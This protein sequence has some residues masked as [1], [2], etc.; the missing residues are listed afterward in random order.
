MVSATTSKSGRRM[1][2]AS[3]C[4]MGSLC[5]SAVTFQQKNASLA[6]TRADIPNC[7]P[8]FHRHSPPLDQVVGRPDVEVPGGGDDGLVAGGPRPRHLRHRA[9]QQARQSFGLSRQRLHALRAPIQAES[10]PIWFPGCAGE[11]TDAQR[12]ELDSCCY[13]VRRVIIAVDQ[14]Q[15]AG[16]AWHHRVLLLLAPRRYS[17]AIL[18]APSVFKL[19]SQTATRCRHAFKDAVQLQDKREW[20]NAHEA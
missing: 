19:I 2:G 11:S 20:R 1:V 5:L 4:D 3:R 13:P 15:V 14:G 8:K 18:H 6:M 12:S 16:A 7:E 17:D 10:P 9:H